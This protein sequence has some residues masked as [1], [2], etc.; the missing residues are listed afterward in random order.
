MEHFLKIKRILDLYE[1]GASNEEVDQVWVE[2]A[3]ND[4][5]LARLGAMLP[6]KDL[7]IYKRQA[8]SDLLVRVDH[9]ETY[10]ELLAWLIDYAE[11]EE[12]Q[13]LGQKVGW[14]E[15]AIHFWYATVARKMALELV[16]G[17][18]DE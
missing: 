8:A 4:R 1:E 15:K 14:K 9:I 6:E 7:E 5:A 2:M 17:K 18:Q 10:D 16:L 3:S 13:S 11:Q 12:K